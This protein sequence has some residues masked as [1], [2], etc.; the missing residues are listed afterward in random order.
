MKTL[1]ELLAIV[2]LAIVAAVLFIG[3]VNNYE[4]TV[5][6]AAG[7]TVTTLQY[8][9]VQNINPQVTAKGIQ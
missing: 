2:V 3:L 1:I 9:P 5:I 4:D 7:G 6:N 8:T